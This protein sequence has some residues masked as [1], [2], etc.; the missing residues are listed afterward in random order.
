MQFKKK[1]KDKIKGW[2]LGAEG[3]EEWEASVYWEQSFHLR[4]W[5]SSEDGWWWWLYNPINLL[6]ATD[7]MINFM[8]YYIFYRNK[9]RKIVNSNYKNR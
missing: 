2:L 9:K 7:E 8:W 6:N 1:K 3:Q 4:V 5:K